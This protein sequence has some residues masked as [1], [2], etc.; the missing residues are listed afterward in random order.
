MKVFRFL[1]GMA[2]LVLAVACSGPK[3]ETVPMG[4]DSLVVAPPQVPT[5]EELT[6]L[7]CHCTS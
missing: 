6:E 4:E 5:L 2:A 1:L 7:L 3:K